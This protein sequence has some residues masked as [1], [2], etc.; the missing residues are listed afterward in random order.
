MEA[1]SQTSKLLIVLLVIL[2]TGCVLGDSVYEGSQ[3][4]VNIKSFLSDIC[5]SNSSLM[6]VMVKSFSGDHIDRSLEHLC[7]EGSHGLLLW[8]TAENLANV[9]ELDKSLKYIGK[10]A[11]G[12]DHTGYCTY[13]AVAQTCSNEHGNLTTPLVILGEKYPERYELRDMVFRKWTNSTRLGSPILAY[14]T[15]KNRDPTYK[16]IDQD[17]SYLAD[18]RMEYLLPATV[19]PGLPLSVYRGKIESYKTVSGETYYGRTFKTINAVRYMSPHTIINVT[20]VGTEERAYRE[21]RAKL[22]TIYTDEEGL[23]WSRALS[24]VEGASI[25]TS[26]SEV[27]VEYGLVAGLYD[28]S[29]LPGSPTVP[30]NVPHTDHKYPGQPILAKTENIHIHINDEVLGQVYPGFRSIAIGAAILFFSVL[31]IAV[32]DIIRRTYSDRRARRLRIGKY[33]Q[34]N[35]K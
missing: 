25:E 3:Q 26:L 24:S 15:L 32:L 20:V 11:S 23:G 5:D 19:A 27:H 2:G 30:S 34:V 12:E 14:A 17:I 21:Y 22:V 13:D 1:K 9:P 4:E 7:K 6:S 8:V 28:E 33:S 31:T 35:G 16:Y 29:Q 10:A 18:S